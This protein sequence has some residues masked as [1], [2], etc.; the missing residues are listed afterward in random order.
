MPRGN[1]AYRV[2]LALLLFFLLGAASTIPLWISA[3]SLSRP[4]L[5]L[6]FAAATVHA[7]RDLAPSYSLAGRIVFTLLNG[8]LFFAAFTVF[9]S[10]DRSET[11]S[12]IIGLA[13]LL[14]AVQRSS[15]RRW[16][17]RAVLVGDLKVVV[18]TVGIV[19][20]AGIL[21][22]TLGISAESVSGRFQGLLN[23]PNIASQ[24]SALT[25]A[26]GW[27][28]YRWQRTWSNFLILLPPLL[29]I[30]LTETRTTFIAIGVALLWLLLKN[31]IR[32]ILTGLGI[33]IPVAFLTT[34]FGLGPLQGVLDRFE[35]AAIYGD[36]F[37]GRTFIW[38]SGVELIRNMPYGTG[39]GSHSAVVSE[40]GGFDNY[41]NSFIHTA[42]EGGIIP[43]LLL[44]AI[45]LVIMVFLATQPATRLNSGIQAA[46]VLGI[47]IQFMESGVF[48]VGQ[49][50][51]YL[52]WFS[53]GAALALSVP[54]PNREAESAPVSPSV[55]RSGQRSLP[56][57][58]TH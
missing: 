22:E 16:Q 39:W 2:T 38:S 56:L 12:T 6:L 21:T 50:F 45:Y 5:L 44:V 35:E 53:V 14:F 27:G 7:T 42:V 9:W 52:F 51:P 58:I 3:A 10:I 37:S 48:G 11:L 8:L 41:H 30:L 4:V 33:G 18:W 26:I 29:T 34:V 25:A 49:P 32:G 47:V 31:G 36:S 54:D 19:L 17:D 24:L 15:T 23:N 46:I 13:A 57:A 28:I 55:P 20:F 40:L 43:V 1:S